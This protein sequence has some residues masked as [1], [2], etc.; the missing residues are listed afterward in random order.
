MV[1]PIVPYAIASFF[2]LSVDTAFAE[3]EALMLPAADAT[4]QEDRPD[5]PPSDQTIHVL[6]AGLS[7]GTTVGRSISYIRLDLRGLPSSTPFKAVL[8]N[9]AKLSLIATSF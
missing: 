3:G 9:E 2:L 7:R 4:D 1:R 8:I 6:A 5:E